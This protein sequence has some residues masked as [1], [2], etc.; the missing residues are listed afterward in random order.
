MI[1]GIALAAIWI[2][3]PAMNTVALCL[4]LRIVCGQKS[5]SRNLQFHQFRAPRQLLDRAAVKVARR[6]IHVREVATGPQ[7]V[8]DKTDALDQLRPVDVGGQAHARDDVAHR[9]VRRTF[10]LVL[11]PD[12]LVGGCSLCR[13]ALLEP[14]QSSRDLRILL[15]Q[16]LHELD[17]EGPRQGCLFVMLKDRADRLGRVRVHAQEPV[18]QGVRFPARGST[19]HDALGSSSKILHEHDPQRDRDRP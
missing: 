2:A 5:R 1:T 18:G 8:I 13:E 3:L 9:H 19:G 12:D 6:K 10:F 7:R 15:P 16:P 14:H 4:M 11:V 17:S